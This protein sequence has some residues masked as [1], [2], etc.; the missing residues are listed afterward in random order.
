MLRTEIIGLVIATSLIASWP[1]GL[2]AAERPA[3]KA[4]LK[5]SS[6]PPTRAIAEQSNAIVRT[7][8]QQEPEPLE[9]AE[10]AMPTQQVTLANLESLAL[11]Y[12]P[13]LAQASA[14]VEAQRGNYTQAG[15]FP[16][17]QVGYLNAS[18]SPSSERQSNGVFI[19]QE[20]VTARKLKLARN[21]E[22]HELNRFG[23]EAEAQRMRVLNDL[24]IRYYEALGAQEARKLAE[25][26]EGIA[27]EG[28]SIAEELVKAKQGSRTDVV[29]AKIQL[30]TVRIS[31]EDAEFRHQ[32]AWQQL[33]TIVGV[34]DL[35]PAALAGQLDSE[36]PQLD[37]AESLQK[38]FSNSPQLFAARSA[39]DQARA[40][41]PLARAQAIPNVTVQAVVEYDRPSRSTTASTLV[42]LPV[43][44]FN[45]NQGNIYRTAAAA[46]GA[47]A[48]I[49]RVQL[50]LR[51][52]LAETFR[53]Y[54]SNR[55][56]VRKFRDA[57]LPGTQEAID[58]STEGFK[59]GEGSFLQMLTARQTYYETN[60]AYVEALTEL[61]KVVVEI[62]GLLLTG[63]LNP[64]EIGTAIQSQAGGGAGRQRA[65]L[66]AVQEGAAKQLLPAAQIGR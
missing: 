46:Q 1:F 54:R 37:F 12:N 60:V 50:V 21:S 44:L 38:L 27:E 24:Q 47:E 32:S 18:A 35:E 10:Q 6:R 49:S 34:P 7:S 2:R 20:F 58:L 63:G 51:D 14:G 3:G 59:A 66:K 62:E 13:T 28:V 42:A 31:R 56:Q 16:N 36:P 8:A 43:P 52:Q 57:I 9:P 48:E 17:P 61:R 53:R 23:W 40:E 39:L 33:A 64:S 22:S 65:L 25:R 55:N 4:T 19:S 45:R 15:L 11:Q 41:Y 30:E 5:A 29:Q 26:L